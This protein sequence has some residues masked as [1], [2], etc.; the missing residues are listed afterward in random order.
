M[1]PT[2]IHDSDTYRQGQKN[3]KKTSTTKTFKVKYKNGDEENRIIT[4]IKSE[5]KRRTIKEI[6]QSDGKSQ[7]TKITTTVKEHI[8]YKD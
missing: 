1:K 8:K 6:V 4:E 5:L 2:G 3:T 7:T